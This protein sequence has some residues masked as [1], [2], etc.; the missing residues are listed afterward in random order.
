MANPLTSIN[1]FFRGRPAQAASPQ[2]QAAGVQV[3]RPMQQN[4]PGAN[5]SAIA[6]IP[7]GATGNG[8]PNPV[9]PSVPIS[10]LDQYK[11]I[12][13][14]PVPKDG[15]QPVDPF[16]TPLLS[17]DPTKLQE[18]ARK[19]NFA[20]GIDPALLQKATSGDS[21]ALLQAINQASQNAFLAASTLTTQVTEGAVT[22]NN[23]RVDSVLENK[24]KEYLVQQQRSEN[25][26]LQHPAA[27]PMLDLAKK[28]L[29]QAHPDKSPTEI[30]KMAEGFLS[31]FASTITGNAK[32]Q[33][34][35]KT[36]GLPDAG[37]FSGW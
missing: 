20:Q 19:M 4:Q 16:A 23:K 9:D 14:T 32:Q 24:F 30:H 36:S 8:N 33:D 11:E 6:Q 2:A 28:Q 26:V 37:D 3:E 15:Q 22:A 7:S 1:D 34:A 29:M 12:W 13:N 18:A 27:A 17:T 5:S 35:G 25:P 21:Q 31:D 10:P